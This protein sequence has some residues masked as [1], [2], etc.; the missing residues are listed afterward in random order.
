VSEPQGRGIS[1]L[2][3]A[4]S[5]V[6]GRRRAPG[7]GETDLMMCEGLDPRGLE[8]L[9]AL[10]VTLLLDRKHEYSSQGFRTWQL[11]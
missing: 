5:L 6:Y 11:C 9:L 10:L 1:T 2:S 8:G 3:R 7:A 4:S